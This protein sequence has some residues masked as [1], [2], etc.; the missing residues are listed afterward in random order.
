[1]FRI[2]MMIGLAA[3][4]TA[5]GCSNQAPPDPPLPP[6]QGAATQA[7]R[8][9]NAQ[10]AERL[11]LNSPLDGDRAQRG[12][13]ARIDKP[14]ITAAD[15]SLVW[16]IDQFD[17]LDGEAPDTV[18]PSLWRQ[19]QL[20]AHHGLFEV[21]DGLYQVR[22]Y[23]LAVMSVIRGT[24]GWI[25][26]DPLTT[27][28]TAAAALELVNNTLG[29]RPV[30]GLIYT[31]S[32]ADH[33]GGARGVL[34]EE[35]AKAREVPIL[36]PQGFSLHAASENLLAG[37]Q[38][39]RRVTLMFGAALPRSATGHVGA[40]LGPGVPTGSIGLLPPTEEIDGR[41]TRRIIDGIT[42]EFIDAAGTEAPAEFMFFL[43]QLRALCTSE[44]A[45][46]TLHNV[47]TLRGARARDALAWSRA[48]DY[49]LAEYGNQADLVFASHHW[50]TWGR[51]AVQSFLRDQ[52]DIYRYVHDQTLRLANAGGT[53][54]EIAE[55]VGAAEFEP[56]FSRDAFHTRG[57]YGTLNH[58]AKAVYQHY[59]GWW[60][61]VP[62][63]FVKRPHEQTAARY[64]EAM[65]GIDGVL[66]LGARAFDSG[67]YRWAAELFNHAVFAQPDHELARGWLAAAYEQLGFQAE[68]GTWRSYFLSAAMELRNGVPQAGD[69]KLGSLDFVRAVPTLELFDSLAARLVPGRL[70]ME[71]VINFT[72]TDRDEQISVHAGRA[73]LVA[74][75]GHHPEAE[76]TVAMPRSSLD[77][78][79]LGELSLAE[80]MNSGAVTVDGD[81]GALPALLMALEKPPFWFNV[82]TP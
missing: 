65:G 28:E 30:T 21:M 69:P 7:T 3:L 76:V 70:D 57:Y 35:D 78:L 25:V 52:R 82:V 56:D 77:A 23:D 19:S 81:A 66:N 62:A 14:A 73:V 45:T 41:G 18:N 63:E 42:F 37:N 51:D 38:M 22:G 60:G 31:H 12:F 39:S 5:A 47:L 46:G 13:L 54:V 11:P 17:F 68:S 58:N 53:P 34:N 10:W 33:F 2:S 61:G 16:A 4:A 55:V 9:A 1:M 26:V 67:D 71:R 59:F 74:R 49:V 44:V 72:F 43:P 64:V 20:A 6:A 32:H 8:E 50:P 15:G 36:A 80:A 79:L 29:H 40:G 75:S 27:R 24:D 48:I